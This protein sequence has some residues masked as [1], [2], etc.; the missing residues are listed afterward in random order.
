M[1]KVARDPER[2]I[3]GGQIVRVLIKSGA[4]AVNVAR[5]RK[6]LGC[7]WKQAFP[8][9]QLQQPPGALPDK[10][11]AHRGHHDRAGVDQ[12]LRAR[13]AGEVLFADRS[14]FTS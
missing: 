12:D 11:I 7:A 13:R 5:R 2:F 9:K 6:E 8:P 14:Q 10:T 4:N 3:D 1:L